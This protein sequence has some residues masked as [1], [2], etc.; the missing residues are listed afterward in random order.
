M[1]LARFLGLGP[2]FVVIKSSNKFSVG[3]VRKISRNSYRIGL[4]TRQF[5]VAAT[6]GTSAANSID[7]SA[8]SAAAPT[9]AGTKP[10]TKKPRVSKTKGKSSSRSLSSTQKKSNTPPLALINDCKSYLKHCQR[11]NVSLTSTV[12]RGTL[13]EYTAKDFLEK[14]LQCFGLMRKGGAFDNGIDL[15]GK[16]DLYHFFKLNQQDIIQQKLLTGESTHGSNKPIK[17][18]IKNSK[19]LNFLTN[20]S[21]KKDSLSIKTDINILVQCKNYTTKIQASTIRELVGIYLQ[22]I[23]TEIETNS[24]FMLLISPS[25]LT[26][27]AQSIIDQ[28]SIPLIHIILSPLLPINREKNVY[29]LKNWTGGS[30]DSVYLNSYSKILLKYLNIE[31]ELQKLKLLIVM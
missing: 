18:I 26:K 9:K 21:N 29:N 11:N 16:W 31:L 24:T 27:Q 20:K 25:P 19:E 13:Y 17:P 22:H 14:K 30:I 3:P 7:S 2:T 6:L 4:N 1:Q 8:S 5:H 15:V 10:S 28:T 12:F 23:K